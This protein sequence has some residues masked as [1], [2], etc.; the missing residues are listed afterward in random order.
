MALLKAYSNLDLRPS[1][2][3]SLGRLTIRDEHSIIHGFNKVYGEENVHIP[4]SRLDLAL[5]RSYGVRPY[6]VV[7]TVKSKETPANVRGDDQEAVVGC[8]LG[9]IATDTDIHAMQQFL[10]LKPTVRLHSQVQK[11]FERGGKVLVIDGFVNMSRYANPSMLA[12]LLRK[13]E[14]SRFH[15]MPVM[16]L[17]P[18]TKM[19][20]RLN[21]Q[22]M[23]YGFR[24]YGIGEMDS[25]PDAIVTGRKSLAMWSK[26][27][28]DDRER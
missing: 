1:G 22:F 9:H 12:F 27:V 26:M 8:M 2:V 25:L 24:P 20:K 10:A 6:D 17:W 15:Q 4:M 28:S 16:L 14:A 3:D 21:E 13:L 7:I 23:H 19:D 18:S 11:M 5:A